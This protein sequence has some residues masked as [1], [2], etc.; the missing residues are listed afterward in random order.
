MSVIRLQDLASFPDHSIAVFAND[1]GAATHI[2]NWLRPFTSKLKL[3][4]SGPAARLFSSSLDYNSVNRFSFSAAFHNCQLVITGTG[5]ETD[6]EFDAILSAN[7]RKIP[8][9]SVLDHWVNYPAR[10]C[11]NNISTYPS[12]LWVADSEAS[13]IASQ[14]FPDI[15]IVTLDNEWIK[16]LTA[17][18]LSLRQQS[19]SGSN[20]L[21]QPAYH[22]L[23]LLEPISKKWSHP[24]L[25]HSNEPGE[26]QALD[27]W[28]QS[29]PKLSSNCLI[30]PSHPD[31]R[32]RLRLHPSEPSDKYSKY[33]NGQQYPFPVLLDDSPSLEHALAWSHIAFGV[34]TQ[35]LAAS[36]ACSI[37]SFSTLPPWGHECRL[38]HGELVQIRHL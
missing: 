25:L 18:V 37:P 7:A 16:H 34:E 1:A 12:T 38:P 22:L 10:F 36:I 6:L 20:F 35:A 28:F 9:V 13:V 30:A 27:Y 11:R 24:T 29:F 33:L 31:F 21:P 26:F 19:S 8:V 14:Q 2:L 4:V 32:I 15:P 23:Y 5:W 17:S 3:C